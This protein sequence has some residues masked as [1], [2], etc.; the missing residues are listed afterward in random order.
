MRFLRKILR[1]KAP[2]TP[3]TYRRD[4]FMDED[5]DMRYWS[6]SATESFATTKVVDG[7][8]DEQIP[9]DPDGFYTVVISR[10]EDRPRN[11]RD[12]N[13]VKW[14]SWGEN[15]DGAGHPDDGMVAIR[16]MLPSPDFGHALQDVTAPE[17]LDSVLGD[18]KPVVQYMSTEDF[19]A[20]GNKPWKNLQ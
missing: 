13:G 17:E 16:N 11:A 18:Y 7:A 5:V 10:E 9:L 14:L 6:I 15:G 8:Y 19:E 20:L 3:K 4:P 2:I 1:G 12:K